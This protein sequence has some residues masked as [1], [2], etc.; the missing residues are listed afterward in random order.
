MGFTLGG[1]WRA[2][3]LC[4]VYLSAD[5]FGRRKSVFMNDESEDMDYGWIV[6]SLLMSIHSMGSDR[7]RLHIGRIL[8]D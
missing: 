3:H 8:E 2:R 6:W 4:G 7:D 1:Y 5:G